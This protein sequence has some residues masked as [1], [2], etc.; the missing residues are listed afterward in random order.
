MTPTSLL[1][2]NA[3]A[4]WFMVGLIWF[5]QIVHY[6]LF[7]AVG[8]RGY[9]A[10]Q[11]QHMNLTGAVVGPPMVIEAITA[12]VLALSPPP[13]AAR[14][15]M[16][17]GL[18]LVVLIWIATAAWSVPRHTILAQGFDAE[19]YAALVVSNWARTLLWTA[20]GG[21]MGL[22]LWRGLQG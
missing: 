3:A 16:P 17:V 21:L 5:V 19:A 18:A 1:L 12:L 6:P 4:T 22:C 10:Y 15:E 11:I 20:R 13:M 2:V 8:E 14:W 7:S 9:A